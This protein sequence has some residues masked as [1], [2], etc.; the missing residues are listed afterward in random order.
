MSCGLACNPRERQPSARLV[1]FN[2]ILI[3]EAS[4]ELHCV[5][6]RTLRRLICTHVGPKGGALLAVALPK[7]TQLRELE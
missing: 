2:R 4:A 1:K 6:V 3:L 5:L 7:L